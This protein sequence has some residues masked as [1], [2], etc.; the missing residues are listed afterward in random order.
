MNEDLEA[1]NEKAMTVFHTFAHNLA[2][3]SD[4]KLAV[5]AFTP[6]NKPHFQV[7]VIERYGFLG[8]RNRRVMFLYYNASRANREVLIDLFEDVVERKELEKKLRTLKKRL[9]LAWSNKVTIKLYHDYTRD[10]QIRKA[11]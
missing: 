7:A 2:K 3:A 6:L 10:E 8:F 11:G 1:V 4:K 5:H 9:A